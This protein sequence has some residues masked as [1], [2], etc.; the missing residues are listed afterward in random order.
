MASLTRIDTVTFVSSLARYAAPVHATRLRRM[1]ALSV[2]A[3]A[4]FFDSASALA[5]AVIHH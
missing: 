1:S 3:L 2:L 5:G 4:A